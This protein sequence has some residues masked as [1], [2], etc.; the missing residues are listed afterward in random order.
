MIFKFNYVKKSNPKKGIQLNKLSKHSGHFCTQSHKLTH[1]DHLCEFYKDDDELIESLCDFIIP[2]L[3]QNEAVFIIATHAHAEKLLIALK[4]RAIDVPQVKVKHQLIFMDARHTLNEIMI[5]G[6]PNPDKFRST[7]V[8]II[9]FMM[10]K[11]SRIRAFGEMVDLL[12]RDGN[13]E[14]TLKLEEM[15]TDL[16]TGYPFSLLCGYSSDRFIHT[17]KDIAS[18]RKTHNYEVSD[19]IIKNLN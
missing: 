14:A 9:K 1:G 16:G 17:Q 19:G 10:L 11:Y 5:D 2:G 15:W 4:N 12:Y 7:I 3:N 6:L 8:P 18:I 13:M